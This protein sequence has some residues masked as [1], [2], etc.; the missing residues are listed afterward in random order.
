MVCLS[1]NRLDL[2][3][4]EP[5]RHGELFHNAQSCTQTLSAYLP[6]G[7]VKKQTV[8]GPQDKSNWIFKTTLK[9]VFW[10]KAVLFLLKN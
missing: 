6:P 5:L 4:G 2:S 9:S 7:A 1:G 10:V 8:P 3:H